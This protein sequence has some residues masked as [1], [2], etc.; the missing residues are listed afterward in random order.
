MKPFKSRP[1]GRT[2]LS[3]TA[4]GLGGSSLGNLYGPVSGDDAIGA[5]GSAYEAGVRYFDTAPLYGNGLGEYRMG[6]ALRVHPGTLRVTLTQ[7][8]GCPVR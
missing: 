4:L 8:S 2:S 1:L 6:H 5:T 7:W 3:L